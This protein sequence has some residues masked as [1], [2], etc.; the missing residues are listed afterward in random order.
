VTDQLRSEAASHFMDDD[1]FRRLAAPLQLLRDPAPAADDEQ[2]ANVEPSPAPDPVEINDTPTLEPSF[3]R[4]LALFD[5]G[6]A[7]LAGLRQKLQ[8]LAT[9]T[10]GREQH[11]RELEEE[12]ARAQADRLRDQETIERLRHELAE[13]DARFAR[14]RAKVHELGAMIDGSALR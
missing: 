5:D 14:V 4:V 7:R 2:R 10:M 13:R 11:L 6:T 1:E 12:L 8:Q 3:E 9:Q